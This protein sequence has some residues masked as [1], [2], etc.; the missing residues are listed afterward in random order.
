MC[1]CGECTMCDLQDMMRQVEDGTVQ[2][3]ESGL[4]QLRETLGR[5]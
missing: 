4:R 2:L 5:E 1:E 3:S